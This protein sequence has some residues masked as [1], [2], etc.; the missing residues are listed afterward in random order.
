M[1]PARNPVAPAVFAAARHASGLPRG[2]SL[3]QSAIAAVR[4]NGG[5]LWYVPQSLAGVFQNSNGTGAPAFSSPVGYVAD[6]AGTAHI[7]QATAGSR[8][9]L[10]QL[11]NGRPG[12][13][14]DGADDLLLSALTTGSAGTYIASFVAT[15]LAL[16]SVMGNGATPLATA[17][18]NLGVTA[19]GAVRLQRSDGAAN[20]PVQLGGAYSAG[21]PVVAAAT[22]S[23][24]AGVLRVGGIQVASGSGPVAT[25][26]AAIA[27]GAA[28]AAGTGLWPGSVALACYAPVVMSAADI[29]AVERFAA[30]LSGA[31]FAA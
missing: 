25:G 9:T 26:A 30:S 21:T 24:S 3:E 5:A 16:R 17:G 12:L 4:S 13:S 8:P 11:A 2:S 10:V 31:A 14:F 23:G 6:Q 18:A 29:I 22:W 28:S 19:A 1:N 20:T 7:T 15:A 27:V